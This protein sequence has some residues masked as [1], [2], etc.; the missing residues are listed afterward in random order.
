MTRARSGASG[1]EPLPSE[2]EHA[3]PP[4][5][6]P[7]RGRRAGGRAARDSSPSGNEAQWAETSVSPSGPTHLGDS[8]SIPL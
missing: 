6:E 5:D 1:F 8:G 2:R 3:I 7:P 4:S